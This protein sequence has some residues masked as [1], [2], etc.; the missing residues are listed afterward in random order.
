MML[1]GL[2]LGGKPLAAQI[3]PP[4]DFLHITASNARNWSQ[5]STQVVLLHGPVS[6]EMENVH[7]RA[8][9]A[10]IW[11]K[12]SSDGVVVQQE[13]Q[14][15]LIGN[16]VVTEDNMQRS[17]P[18]LF[19]N[20]LV[21]GDISLTTTTGTSS[22]KLNEDESASPLY[23]KALVLRK[24]AE[25]P[26]QYHPTT[27]PTLPYEVLNIQHP[28]AFEFKHIETVET[29]QGRVAAVLSGGVTIIYRSEKNE[30]LEFQAERAVV[31]TKLKSLGELGQNRQ[32]KSIQE[33]VESIY[34]EGDARITYTPV[35]GKGAEQRLLA[36]RAF[37]ELTTDRA[38][39]TDV[40]IHTSDPKSVVPVTVRAQ[41]VRQLAHDEF[42]VD[43]VQLSSSSF[44]TPSFS[45]AAT[46]AYVQQVDTDEETNNTQTFFQ[47]NNA[48]IDMWGVP[49]FYLP[50]T[51]GSVSN[52]PIALR[53][54]QF[55]KSDYF[56]FHIKTD[57][58]FFETIGEPPPPNLDID[59]HLDYF[60]TRG[61][62]TGVDATYYGG[63]L[64]NNTKEAWD[65]A[66][67]FHA[68]IVA[69]TGIDQFGGS[70]YAVDS[71]D[72]FDKAVR[73]HF[74]WT[75][76]YFLPDDWQVQ[77]RAGY[78]SDPNYLE[79]WDPDDFFKD[80]PHDLSLYAKHQT[81]TSA[82]TI[83]GEAQPN[84]FVTTS[85]DVANQ[86]SVQ[87]LPEL[88][89]HEIGD[90]FLDDKTTFFSDNSL[91]ALNFS[92]SGATLAQ[93][94]YGPGLSPGIPSLGVIGSAGP[95]DVPE[96]ETYRGDFRQELDY[97]IN[98]SEFKVVPYV[99][100]RYTG[101]SNSIGGSI[102]NRALTALGVRA[103]TAFWA[104]DDTA[105]STLFDI[106]RIRHVVEPE[107][108]LFTSA[109]NVD[110]DNLYIYDQDVDA[111]NDI[112]GGQLAL[113]QT[114]QTKRG[115][116]G[117]W[118]SVDFL[119]LDVE[120]NG[121][122]NKPPMSQLDPANPTYNLNG[123]RGAYFY[124]EPE[125]SIPRD[126]INAQSSW[127]VSDQFIVLGD[128]EWNADTDVLATA[129]IGAAIKTLPRVVY[130]IGTR[131]IAPLD[132][133]VTTV[134]VSYDL[135]EKYTVAF[136]QSFDFSQNQDVN[137]T[138]YL[139]RKFDSFTCA[140]E[141]FYDA[142]IKESGVSFNLYPNGLAGGFNTSQL[143]NAFGP[144][145]R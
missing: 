38:I 124:S 47:A 134:A 59:Y 92:K 76:Q 122:M 34:L 51:S 83:L 10:I 88:T 46:R 9:S 61:P 95:A 138:G 23:Q 133:N 120:A 100:G 24:Q 98:A 74:L 39:L 135:S 69:D 17:G 71:A 55:G 1:F 60:D 127:R 33:N 101:Y 37:Y 68:Y 112:T 97:P 123:F 113:R 132:S 49:I 128:E 108:N 52:R 43:H 40:I 73:G 2:L 14:V 42:E 118:H 96:S 136:S 107:V 72:M 62:A 8:N 143:G 13:A 139:V 19:I 142:T 126:S 140:L 16:A 15:A 116:P 137:S 86:F 117:E 145:Q 57:W 30:S 84:N 129:S 102:Q 7:L 66:G 29:P 35:A 111:I 81:N 36:N 94:G 103:S 56:G 87:R 5:G 4:V 85:D 93:Q 115:G 45:V 12:P 99:V 105:H 44:A 89:Y 121:F 48:F 31:F 90:S 141:I 80:N 58:G 109:E 18:T 63:Y 130:F 144:Q 77:L 11:L 20:A 65:F 27:V 119:T 41:T 21:R 54:L 25:G 114:W 125:A 104:V 131:Y 50:Y 70:R 67:D 32:A 82:L 91:S 106:N 3:Q 110:R 53:Q 78:A 79:E 28:S 64:N 75:H 22:D 6:I 26:P